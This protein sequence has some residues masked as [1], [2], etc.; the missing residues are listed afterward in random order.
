M[1]G[2][3]QSE[4]VSV[5]VPDFANLLR[6]SLNTNDQNKKNYL[7]EAIEHIAGVLFKPL[8]RGSIPKV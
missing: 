3:G 2:G 7:N 8:S 1:G 5:R 6:G 4:F